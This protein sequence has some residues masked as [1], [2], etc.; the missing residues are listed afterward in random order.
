MIGANNREEGMVGLDRLVVLSD[1]DGTVTL[2]DVGSSLVE[3]F[4]D[5]ASKRAEE[6]WRQGLI[7]SAKSHERQYSTITASEEE[8]ESYIETMR[9][10][11]TFL[12]FKEYLEKREIPLKIVSDGFDFY[13]EHLLNTYGLD[14][15]YQSNRLDLKSMR[16]T[17]PH[18]NPSCWRCANCKVKAVQSHLREGERVIYIGDGLSD[19]YAALI[20][21]CIFVRR[22]RELEKVLKKRGI[23]HTPFHTFEEILRDMEKGLSYRFQDLSLRE[24]SFREDEDEL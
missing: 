12:S 15:E 7:G 17:F 11:R 1:F 23:E 21:D 19:L 24:C 10:D 6:E 3:R 4:A 5:P 9:I 8:L 16:F 14:V 22:G 20:A 18:Q 2:C 13:I